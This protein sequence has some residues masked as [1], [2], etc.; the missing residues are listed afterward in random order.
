[1]ENGIREWC[2]SSDKVAN[3]NWNPNPNIRKVKFNWNNPDNSNSEIGARLEISRMKIL[4]RIFLRYVTLLY[5]R[6]IADPPVDHLGYF[7][8]L[9]R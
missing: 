3:G 7:D 4:Q 2:L 1:M 5:F 6:R 8:Q 9:F